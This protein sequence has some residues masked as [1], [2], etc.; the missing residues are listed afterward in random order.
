MKEIYSKLNRVFESRVRL[1][2]MAALTANEEMEFNSLKELLELTDGNLA[3]SLKILERERYIKVRKQFIGKKPNTK[4]AC[5]SSGKKAF[6]D[7]LDLLEKLIKI[8]KQ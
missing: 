6:S 7:H 8:Q 3:S 2:I 1:G 4:Y 5:T